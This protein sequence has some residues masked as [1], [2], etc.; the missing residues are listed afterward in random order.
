MRV[1]CP[2]DFNS[3]LSRWKNKLQVLFRE[4]KFLIENAVPPPDVILADSISGTRNY[5]RVFKDHISHAI[6]HGKGIYEATL[7]LKSGE[8]KC[9]FAVKGDER[10]FPIAL[11]SAVGKLVREI[12][13]DAFNEGLADEG[14]NGRRVSGYRDV[15]TRKACLFLRKRGLDEKCIFRER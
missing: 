11:A 5:H 12:A 7:H 3:G 13:M 2:G 10:F 15:V 1:V 14:W 6:P 8:V 9:F 4:F